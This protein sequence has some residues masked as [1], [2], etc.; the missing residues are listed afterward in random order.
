M[1]VHDSI[2]ALLHSAAQCFPDRPAI[3]GLQR[4]P[5][6]HQEL[7]VQ[8]EAMVA[9]INALGA[10]RGDRIVIVLPNGPEM[11]VCA[12]AA[13]AT[14]TS[15]PLN[16]GYAAAELEFYLSD[17]QPRAVIVEAGAD[18]PVIAVASSRGI[19]VIRLH[20][21][22]ERPAGVCRLEGS[23]L[24]GP[25]ARPGMAGPDD[26]AL[27]LHTSGSTSRPKMVPLTHANLCRS[28]RNIGKS[29]SLSPADRC[30]NIMPL[31]HVHGLVGAAMSSLGAGASVVCTP[32]FHAPRFFDW[33]DEFRPTWYTAVPT[34]HQGIL[35]RAARHPE[36]IERARLRFIRSCSSALAPRLMADLEAAFSVPVIEAYG[37]TEASHQMAVNPLPPRARKPGSVGL[38]TGCE[39]AVMDAAGSLLPAGA[40]GEVVI[41]G[42]N[43]TR[44]Y[45]GSA[46]ANLESFVDG[47]FRTG[48]QGFLDAEGYLF[49]TGRTKEIINRGGEKISPREIDEVLLDHPAV[50]QAFAFSIPS[51]Q[52]GEEVGA[53]VVLRRNASASEIALLEFA[54]GRLAD[55]KVPRRIVFLPELP[56][57]PTGKPQRIGFATRLGLT[58]PAPPEASVRGFSAS[59]QTPVESR[60]AAIWSE[61]LDAAPAGVDHNFFD[62]GGDS[63][64]GTQLIVRVREEFSVE[65][66]M[67]RL[68]NSP[69][70]RAIAEWIQSAPRSAAT[71]RTRIPRVARDGPLPLSFAQQRMWFIAQIEEETAA[72]AMPA[73]VRIR[74]RLRTDALRFAIQSIIERHE[75]LRYTYT[76]PEGIPVPAVAPARPIDLPVVDLQALPASDRD[77]RLHQIAREEVF[78]PFDLF[79]DLPLRALLLRMAPDD[80]VLLLTVHHIVSDGWSKSIFFRELSAFYKAAVTRAPTGLPEL[81]IQYGDY[82]VWQRRLLEGE[83]GARLAAYWTERL[84]G[85]PPVLD[86]PSARP[87]LVRQTFRGGIER[88]LLPASLAE[89]VRALS[90]AESATPFMT[91]LAAFQALLSRY[92]GQ[93][94]ICV[95]APIANRVRKE[96]EHLIGLFVNVLVMRTDLSGDPS[97]RELLARVRET[98]LGAYDHQDLP[99]ER[100]LEIAQPE[101]SLSHS[102]LF[103][104]MFQ[105]RNF[106]EILYELEGLRTEVIPIDPGT[107]QFELFLEVTEAADGLA[108]SLTYNS[109]RFDAAAARRILG[110]YRTLLE[111]AVGTPGVAIGRLPLLTEPERS[112]ILLEWN[113]TRAE[114]PSL[115]VLKLFEAQVARTPSAAAA[116][117]GRRRWSYAELDRHASGVARRLRDIGCGPGALVAVCVERS[118]EMLGAIL[119][120]WKAGAAYVPLDPSY[121][122]ER[123]AF[124]LE[125]ASPAALI[126]ETQFRGLLGELSVPVLDLAGAPPEERDCGSAAADPGD[127]AFVIYTSGSTG[128]PKGVAVRHGGL[129]NCLTFLRREILPSPVDVVLGHTTISFDI[130]AVEMFLPL[131]SGASVSLIGRDVAADGRLLADAI[132]RSGATILQATPTTWQ[133]LLESG[134]TPPAGLRIISGGEPLT[135]A[136]AARLLSCGAL[137]NCYGPSETTIYSTGC[138]VPDPARASLIGRPIA[139]TRAYVLDGN[140]QPVPADAAGELYIGGH[141]L[142]RGY[143]NRPDLTAE[144]F[145]PDPFAEEPGARLYRTGDLVRLLPDGNLDFLGRIDDQVKLRGYRIELGEIETVLREHPAVL[146]AAAKVVEPAPGDRRIAAWFV[147]R[148]GR[149]PSEAELREPLKRKLPPYMQP[150]A[151]VSVPALPM[152]PSGKC[153]R[154]ALR[155]PESATLHSSRARRSPLTGMEVLMVQIWENTLRRRP[156]GLDDDFFELGGHSLLG[157]RLLARVEKAFGAKLPLVSFFIAPTA[158]RML[159]LLNSPGGALPASQVIP[160]WTTGSRA[161]LVLVDPHQIYRPLTLRLPADQPIYGLSLFDASTLPAP[162]RL[163]QIAARQ[164]DALRRFHAAG[165]LV[166]AG[167]CAEGVLAYEM[168]QQLRALGT[169]V[170]LLV[171]FDSY[172]PAAQGGGPWLRRER[173]R[174]H[175]AA[176]SRL[177]AAQVLAYGRDRLRT[178]AKRIRTESWRAGYRRRI[179]SGRDID[180]NLREPAQI[181]AL[182]AT[183]YSPQPYLGPVLLFRPQSRPAGSFADAAFGWSELVPRLRTVDVPGNHKDMFQEP[184]VETMAAALEDLL[185]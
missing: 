124:I 142:A 50:D 9:E 70:L 36:V 68:F 3:L 41:R 19:P 29:L 146:A 63:I 147:P 45:A 75:V 165:P 138:R 127:L 10:G 112:R 93:T 169:E 54:A 25:P 22:M 27:V 179:Q 141:G 120:V 94:D 140:R 71:A 97:F 67:F 98:A 96:T 12:L 61:L 86:L 139:N 88:L 59:P 151:L 158:G 105:L 159:E 55:F 168:A 74:G 5:L 37:M 24:P 90:R 89:A 80:H 40:A 35:A 111:A 49:L 2:Y 11:A 113:R 16:P 87:R 125:D 14:C 17:L 136:I 129:T 79:A 184:N 152:T 118:L 167:W 6:T 1:P 48:D 7:F 109:D 60:L 103:Q 130:A 178:L 77:S 62:L 164:V 33:L 149:M 21:C 43:V 20:P 78:R 44:G 119:G 38:P 148:P 117:H 102:P 72:Y 122:R 99:L 135:P 172:N 46:G 156:I 34:M 64:L 182:A 180:P 123:L 85:I 132:G 162:F 185:R 82:A 128:R 26:V 101:R 181:L 145:V 69:T 95:G 160:L 42:A 39:I 153:D 66:P 32:G 171:L 30:L 13:A 107:S 81:P 161:P 23:A 154:S 157:A 114:Y 173:L 166:L 106:P 76:S 170:A 183:E 104:V 115:S 52:L 163:E 4:D 65:L 110:H 175:I 100:L 133:L 131:I 73:A 8:V 143:L 15:A 18:S 174:Y 176:A 31:F 155:L 57:G 92:S 91:L 28:A 116:V 144:R 84:R 53:A 137:W 177:G 47:W 126:T 150:A 51:A 56:K 108:C 134:W 121:P 83:T 58:A